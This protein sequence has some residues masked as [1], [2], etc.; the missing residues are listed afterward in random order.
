M[1]IADTR[2]FVLL[3]LPFWLS[4]MFFKHDYGITFYLFDLRLDVLLC[5]ELLVIRGHLRME[6]TW[7]AFSPCKAGVFPKIMK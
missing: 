7:T 1:K 4:L 3:L 6:E 2:I 5:L